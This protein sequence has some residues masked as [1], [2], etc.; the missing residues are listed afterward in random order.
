MKTNIFKSLMGNLPAALAIVT[1]FLFSGLRQGEDKVVNTTAEQCCTKGYNLSINQ[2]RQ[3][4]L[5]SLKTR[6]YEGGIYKKSE[7]LNVISSIASDSVYIMNGMIECDITK[8]TMLAV[9]STANPKVSFV[10]WYGMGYCY[11]CP[12]P[13]C[14][15][16]FC[17]VS[18]DRTCVTYQQFLLQ[19]TPVAFRNIPT[20]EQ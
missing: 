4:M 2:L 20:A 5:D 13:C 19:N 11:P 9:T 16:R 8:G 3:F 6:K 7:L 18:I 14:I 1:F 10:N 12:K 15:R 17:V